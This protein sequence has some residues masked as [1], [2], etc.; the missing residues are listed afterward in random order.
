MRLAGGAVPPH[1]VSTPAD[2]ARAAVSAACRTVAPIRYGSKEPGN[3]QDKQPE[4]GQNRSGPILTQRSLTGNLPFPPALLSRSPPGAV[5]APPSLLARSFLACQS[6][7]RRGP[8]ARGGW[9]ATLLAW[10]D[11]T[12]CGDRAWPCRPAASASSIRPAARRRGV[13]GSRG[14]RSAFFFFFKKKAL[15]YDGKWVLHPG[16]IEAVNQAFAPSEA[17][18]SR[19]ARIIEA[20]AHATT[21]EQRGAVMLGDEMIDE[22]SRKMAEVIV[23]RGNAGR[24]R[25]GPNPV[26]P[27]NGRRWPAG[28][29]SDR[30]T[31]RPAAK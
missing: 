11:R 2:M 26:E 30:T 16:Q 24:I 17:D 7:Q 6:R 13:P 25:P 8:L 5:K 22:A 10:S 27:R 29:P 12:G 28:K 23:A 20:Y 21:V 1:A 3:A 18:Y 9:V 15:G 14:R 19:A 31:G 4:P